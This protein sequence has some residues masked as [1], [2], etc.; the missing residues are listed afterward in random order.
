MMTARR[1]HNYANHLTTMLGNWFRFVGIQV[2]REYLRSLSPTK[3]TEVEIAALE[4][5]IIGRGQSLF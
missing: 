5:S 3:R 4:A 1:E 2:I